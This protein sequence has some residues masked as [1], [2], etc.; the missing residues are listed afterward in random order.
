[1]S[2]TEVV[3]AQALP[4]HT[5]NQ[6]VELKA[7][8]HAFQLAPGKSLNIHTDS[9]YAFHILLSHAMGGAWVTYHKRRISN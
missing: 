4:A 6:Q 1:V 7:F 5:T 2:E 3:E 9:K 8:T